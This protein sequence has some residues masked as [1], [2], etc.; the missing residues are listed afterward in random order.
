[1][2]QSSTGSP[3]VVLLLPSPRPPP[4]P[5]RP[6]GPFLQGRARTH[7]PSAAVNAQRRPVSQD[8]K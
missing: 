2:K 1:M 6:G 7:I 5:L 3:G 8:P 4:K